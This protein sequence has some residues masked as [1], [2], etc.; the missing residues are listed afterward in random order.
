MT[1][2]SFTCGE[3]AVRGSVQAVEVSPM[4]RLSPSHGFADHAP[5]VHTHLNVD[6][7]HTL[8]Q[9]TRHVG[10]TNRTFGHHEQIPSP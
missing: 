10:G 8:G 4:R 1:A 3:I 2:P 5:H 7:R 9:S 6:M